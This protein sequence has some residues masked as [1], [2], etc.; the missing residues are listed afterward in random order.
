MPAVGVR[1][2]ARI[3]TDVVG[4]TFPTAGHLASDG[5]PPPAAG[6]P[7][8]PSAAITP[9]E[10]PAGP[11]KTGNAEKEKAN[12]QGPWWHWP[13]TLRHSLRHPQGRIPVHP[14]AAMVC[15]RTTHSAPSLVIANEFSGIGHDPWLQCQQQPGAQFVSSS[16]PSSVWNVRVLVLSRS[17]AM[18]PE[19]AVDCVPRLA[20]N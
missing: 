5:P 6:A 16:W 17:D 8:A 2:A 19:L 11:I 7:A 9:L 10:D 1:T 13:E 12:N 18:P 4:K 20:E 15:R 3:L 14:T